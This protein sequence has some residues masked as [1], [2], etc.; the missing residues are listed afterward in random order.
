M[1]DRLASGRAQR[2]LN[3]IDDFNSVE[4][5]I[6]IDPSLPAVRVI[7]VLEMIVA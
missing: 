1:S 6:E 5:W 2:T 7:R 3:I 4:L